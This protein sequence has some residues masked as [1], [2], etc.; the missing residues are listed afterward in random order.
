MPED[1]V[2]STPDIYRTFLFVSLRFIY[3]TKYR[4]VFLLNI[5][6]KLNMKIK[7]YMPNNRQDIVDQKWYLVLRINRKKKK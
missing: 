3:S 1:R 6:L 7:C 2:F 4:V 5:G